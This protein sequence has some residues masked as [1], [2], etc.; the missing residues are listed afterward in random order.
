V[1]SLYCILL[2]ISTNHHGQPY[3]K[4]ICCSYEGLSATAS[5]LLCPYQAHAHAHAHAHAECPR[6]LVM[7]PIAMCLLQPDTP[8][9]PSTTQSCNLCPCFIRPM[10]YPC[11]RHEY[12]CC[13]RGNVYCPRPPL[14]G[15]PCKARLDFFCE[16][17][18]ADCW[19]SGIDACLANQ[20]S[21]DP[22]P[23]SFSSLIDKATCVAWRLSR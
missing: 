6:K 12:M 4:V 17:A 14:P 22:C 3:R 23:R 2:K 7:H 20:T 21:Y 18:R 9:P 13:S 8:D 10:I 5:T 16:I 15:A 11:S 19:G 1:S